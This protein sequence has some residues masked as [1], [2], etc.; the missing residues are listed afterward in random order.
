MRT[1]LFLTPG[2]SRRDLLTLADGDITAVYET[3]TSKGGKALSQSVEDATRGKFSCLVLPS[4]R[5]PGVGVRSLLR[6]LG[7]LADLR[8]EVRSLAEPWLTLGME[9][10]ALVA[11]LHHALDEERRAHVRE[12]MERA[13]RSG[14]RPGRPPAEIPREQVL[15]A[16]RDG[17]SLRELARRFG[18]GPSTIQRFLANH[19]ASNGGQL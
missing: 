9:Q 13:R 10:A 12:G 7:V 14:R 11:W 19:R 1:A 8:V 5:L 16:A 3:G 15:G 4:M 6:H 2:T 17:A 18:L